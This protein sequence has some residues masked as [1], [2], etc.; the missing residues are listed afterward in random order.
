VREIFEKR[1][2][3]SDIPTAFVWMSFRSARRFGRY[4]FSTPSVSRVSMEQQSR[5]EKK[6]EEK[7]KREEE[8][9]CL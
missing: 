6:C 3:K 9:E 2:P 1:N 5:R 8:R 4:T 7:I